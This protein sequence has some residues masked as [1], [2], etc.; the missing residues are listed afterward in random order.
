MFITLQ[1]LYSVR[2]KLVRLTQYSG[3]AASLYSVK[4]ETSSGG[5]LTKLDEFIIAHRDRHPAE[6]MNI[7]G[8]LNSM[9]NE[10]GCVE[11]FFKLDEGLDPEDMVCALF[12]IPGV[13]LRL[14]CI[15]ISEQIVI[16]GSGGPKNVRAW[17]DDNDLRREVEAMMDVSAVVR[18]KME[19]NM[20]WQSTNGLL[21][22]GNLWI[23]RG[24]SPNTDKE[25]ENKKNDDATQA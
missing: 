25:K 13:N 20:L 12:D 9:G 1:K 7:I 21:L 24:V 19:H 14:Y 10:T 2:S 6:L 5:S 3:G 8:R 11:D 18:K 23:S 17:Q 22:E 16:L 4:F 15:R